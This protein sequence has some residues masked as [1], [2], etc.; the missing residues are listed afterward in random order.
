MEGGEEEDRMSSSGEDEDEMKLMKRSFDEQAA[1]NIFDDEEEMRLIQENTDWLLKN[2]AVLDG[3]VIQQYSTGLRGVC[4]SKDIK[5]GT[6]VMKIP[7]K[8][9]ILNDVIEFSPTG[10]KLVAKKPDE[11]K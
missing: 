5:A 10:K 2:G 9:I 11:F 6:V 1:K 3:L 4:V 7:L 8:C